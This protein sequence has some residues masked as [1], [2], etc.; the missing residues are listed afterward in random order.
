MG[1]RDLRRGHRVRGRGEPRRGTAA[2]RGGRRRHRAGVS[3][4][5]SPA[6]STT[7]AHVVSLEE[8]LTALTNDYR[9]SKGLNA[10][11][12][13]PKIRE[14]ARGQCEHM[15][16]HGFFSHQNPEGQWPWE[17]ATMAGI[18][19]IQYGENLAAGQ[20]TAR[21]AFAALLASSGHRAVIEDPGWTHVGCGFAS[22]LQSRHLYYWAQNFKRCGP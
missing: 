21:Q 18:E 3:Q 22:D 14:V 11:V 10:L 8:E 4:R 1:G 13:D 12:D 5:A 17:R 15:I 7:D 19:W 2:R 20:P 6:C 9:V 16:V